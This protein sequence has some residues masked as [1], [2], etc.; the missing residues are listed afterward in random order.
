MITK[1]K[2]FV[3]SETEIQ[4]RIFCYEYNGGICGTDGSDPDGIFYKGGLYPNTL[5]EGY[6]GING[7]VY[8]YFKYTYPCLSW[9][10]ELPLPMRCM[11]PIARRD[12]KKQQILM[13]MFR[14]FYQDHGRFCADW[15]DCA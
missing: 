2:G 10:W 9:A 8:G 5:S 3:K 1:K 12:I 15:P 7:S 4:D 6:V 13:R 11:A 14:T